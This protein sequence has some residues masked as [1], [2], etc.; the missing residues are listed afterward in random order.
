MASWSEGYIT[1]VPYTSGF[2]RE[3]TPAW[4]AFTALLG[5]QRPPDLARPF[6]WAEL[7]CGG[8]LT[9]NI[10]AATNPH[11]DV[12]GFDFNPAHIEDAMRLATAAGLANVHFR[13]AS[14]ADIARDSGLPQFDFIVA[15]GVYSWIAP[16]FRDDLLAFIGRHLA[17]GG[18][19][20]I[21]YNTPTGWD[22]MAPLQHLMRM[23]AKDMH[24]RSDQL[25]PAILDR[26]ERL[27]ESEAGFFRRNP[28]MADRLKRLRNANPRYVA[29]EYLNEHWHPLMF[30]EVAAQLAAVKCAFIASATLPDNFDNVSIPPGVQPLLAEAHGTELRETLRDFGNAQSFRRDVFRRGLA[31]LGAAEQPTILANLR[32]V[33]IQPRPPGDFRFQT[34]FTEL[35]GNMEIYGPLLDHLYSTGSLSFAEAREVGTATPRSARLTIET[36]TFLISSGLAHPAVPESVS[37]AARPTVAAFNAAVSRLN[38][39]GSECGVFASPVTGS[40]TAL[41]LLEAFCRQHLAD[42]AGADSAALK[43]AMRA[44]LRATERQLLRDGQAVTEEA[45]E[46]KLLEEAIQRLTGPQWPIR[47]ALGIYE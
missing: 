7:G 37:A 16:H 4:L 29:H 1:D 23:L 45:E 21:S 43:A 27:V 9:T 13:E 35:P 10:V 42:P 41:E 28:M 5:G 8:G 34:S 46:D 17:P 26:I 18:L 25:M 30:A 44:G 31:P 19:V 32:V 24:G 11:A 40:A 3:L 6:R 22:A 15:H 33:P 38:G 20:Y 39:A 14:F 12:W 2:Y 36:L 47:R